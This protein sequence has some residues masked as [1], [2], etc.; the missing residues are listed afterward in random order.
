MTD[1]LKLIK[2]TTDHFGHEFV[3]GDCGQQRRG[4]LALPIENP[5]RDYQAGFRSVA[6]LIPR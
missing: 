2:A 1:I 6:I 4:E 3:S 5:A